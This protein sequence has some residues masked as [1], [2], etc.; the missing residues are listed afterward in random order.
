MFETLLLCT[1]FLTIFLNVITQLLLTG[2]VDKPLL[3]LGISHGSTSEGWSETIP[4]D[5]DFGVVLLRVGTASLEATGLRGWG[6]E[7]TGVVAAHGLDED[8]DALL[9][10]YG[11]IRLT[12]GGVLGV[13][14]GSVS[15][16]RV[17]ARGKG[18][19]KLRTKTLTG[20]N[21]E[22]RDVDLGTN[23]TSPGSRRGRWGISGVFTLNAQWLAEL[24]RFTLIASGVILGA[25]KVGWEVLRGRRKLF[26]SSSHDTQDSQR[27]V[28]DRYDTRSGQNRDEEDDEFD[29][30][31]KEAEEEIL[32]QRF[33][34]GENVSDDDDDEEYDSPET[35]KDEDG[36]EEDDEDAEL[37][38]VRLFH[39]YI[40]PQRAPKHTLKSKLILTIHPQ[41]LHRTGTNLHRKHQYRRDLLGG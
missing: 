7:V 11:S 35:D 5:E 17:G 28:L 10:K 38:T 6:N 21:N 23:P 8:D 22:V 34:R 1:I 19:G 27:N 3:G 39:P 29:Y 12:R 41:W 18:K 15:S 40:P 13:S 33:L 20:W 16:E 4:W 2:R 9:R 32:Y 25:V 24:K 26:Q 36:I 31:R 14:P 30:R 37:E